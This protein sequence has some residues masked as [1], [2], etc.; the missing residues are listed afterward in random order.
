MTAR[1]LNANETSLAWTDAQGQEWVGIRC[2]RD[3]ASLVVVE[4][5]QLQSAVKAWMAVG[6]VPSAYVE[7]TGVTAARIAAAKARVVN[8][9]ESLADQIT[10]PVPAAEKL[11]WDKKEQAARAHAAGT[12]TPIQTALLQGEF[13]TVGLDVDLDDLAAKI[14]ARA[15]FFTV[16]VAKIAG[17]RRRTMAAIDALGATPTQEQLEATLTAAKTEA[18]VAFAQLMTPSP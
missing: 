18:E 17:I 6:N 11:G 14:I 3:G 9:A 13:E 4:D 12:A 8:F 15:D 5:G 16:A 1:F 10:R 2:R 7:P